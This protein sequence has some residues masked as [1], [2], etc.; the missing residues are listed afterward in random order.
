MRNYFL[1]WIFA[2]ISYNIFR[3]KNDR[4]TIIMEGFIKRMPQ[5]FDN[6]FDYEE[7]DSRST[8]QKDKGC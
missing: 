4:N 5:D 7:L 6:T 3:R 1:R 8:E 2:K